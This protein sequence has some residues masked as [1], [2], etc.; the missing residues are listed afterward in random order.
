MLIVLNILFGFA[1]PG[2][3]NA[4]H[5]GGLVT[6]L[7]LGAVIPPTRV[8]TMGSYWQQAKGAAGAHVARVPMAVPI[9]AVVAVAVVVVAGL[10]YGT[11]IR[12]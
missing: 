4:A 6:G 8:D 7:W 12:A 11:S 1:V 2:I 9:L 10:M 5:L 3:D